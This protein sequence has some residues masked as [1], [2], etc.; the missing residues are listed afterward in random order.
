MKGTHMSTGLECMFWEE[1]PTGKW[2]YVLESPMAPK[3]A[4]FPT[5]GYA[6]AYGPYADYDEAE[7]S[8][9]KNHANPGGWFVEHGEARGSLAAILGDA[10]RV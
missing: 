3:M 6:T 8:L 2:Y 9:N 5:E 1:A 7:D 10:V 4:D